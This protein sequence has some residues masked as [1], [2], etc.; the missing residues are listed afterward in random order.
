MIKT[1]NS[2]IESRLL[3]IR[4]RGAGGIVEGELFST[5]NRLGQLSASL[6]LLEGN[7]DSELFRYF[8]VAAI[9]ILESH[10]RH[11]VASFVDVGD[12]YRSRGLLI[13]KDSQKSAIDVLSLVKGNVSLGEMI[14]FAL[15]FNS[16]ASIEVALDG[17][18]GGSVK[19][20]IA[21][22]RWLGYW[23]QRHPDHNL[24]GPD[25]NDPG[26][27]V[28]NVAELWGAL[29]M[30]F[31]H[32]HI[33]A[34]EA[35]PNFN[36]SRQ[37]ASQAIWAVRTLT[38]ALDVVLWTTA[39]K[40]EPITFPEMRDKAVL[41]IMAARRSIAAV[42][43]QIRKSNVAGRASSLRA[44]HLEWKR[45][46]ENLVDFASVGMVGSPRVVTRCDVDADAYENWLKTIRTL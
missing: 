24:V 26:P 35:S 37:H 15:P 7:A 9:A 5:K 18:I 36:V 29:A 13:I 38:E 39:W 22:V 19:K 20:I 8:P 27:L 45:H 46:R 6:D 25:Q 17:L 31:E 1:K 28:K 2:A 14:S 4:S 16:V 12:P 42:L 34:H 10:F 3:D 30:A 41:R 23:P 21:G 33:V 40:E 44:L 32:R 11:I 43:R